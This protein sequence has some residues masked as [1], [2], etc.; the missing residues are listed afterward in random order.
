MIKIAAV[1]I[2]KRA[3]SW[4]SGARRT[5]AAVLLALAFGGVSVE[6]ASAYGVG[7]A[8][9]PEPTP[10]D[11]E[12]GDVVVGRSINYSIRFVNTSS[13][14]VSPMQLDAGSMMMTPSCDSIPFA[15]TPPCPNPE[16]G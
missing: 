1:L 2:R 9:I 7:L 11:P 6:H 14:Q 16:L 10:F 8:A 3:D 12:L 13:A 15:A 5:A 4:S